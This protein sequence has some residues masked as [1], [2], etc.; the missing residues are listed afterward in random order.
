MSGLATSFVVLLRR[1]VS[2][3]DDMVDILP[4]YTDEQSARAADL[5]RRLQLVVEADVRR[6]DRTK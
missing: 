2:I 1:G 3:G 6:S 5:A 4:D